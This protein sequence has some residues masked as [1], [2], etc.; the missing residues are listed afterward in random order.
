ML[1]GPPTSFLACDT[2]WKLNNLKYNTSPLYKGAELWKLLPLNI[3]TSNS[4]F[5]F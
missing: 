3:A 2:K 4:F 1:F 5:Q